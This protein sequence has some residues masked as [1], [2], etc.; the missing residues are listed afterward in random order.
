MAQMQLQIEEAKAKG[1][2]PADLSSIQII[3]KENKIANFQKEISNR[4]SK[5]TF[6]LEGSNNYELWRDEVLIQALEIKAKSILKNIKTSPPDN[7]VDKDKLI[8]EIKSEALFN[9]LL[10]ALKSTVRQIIKGRINEDNKNAA[11]LWT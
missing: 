1:P 4:N 10:S 2:A 6:K 5:L 9:M 3:H 8:W 11:K 7:L